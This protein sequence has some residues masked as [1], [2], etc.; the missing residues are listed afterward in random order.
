MLQK[1]SEKVS[2]VFAEEGF[3]FGHCLLVEDDVR[4]LIDSGAG[5]AL[6]D[7]HPEHIDILINSHHHIDHIRGNDQC[8]NAKVFLHPLEQQCLRE[9]EKLV[10]VTGWNELMGED[11]ATSD[12]LGITMEQMVKSWQISGDIVDGQIIDCGSTKIEVLHTPGHS[13][14]HCSFFFPEDGLVFL[15]D[16]CL[17]KVGPWYGG[18]EADIDEFIDSINRIIDLKPEKITTGHMNKVSTDYHDLI[19]YRNRIFK[20]ENKILETLKQQPKSINELADQH[21][22][23]RLHPSV[24]VLFWEKYMLKNHLERLIRMNAIEKE[25]EGRYYTKQT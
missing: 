16:I 8:P 23:Y 13:S 2:M 14:G 24:F 1:L 5:K 20:R 4:L 21:L 18:P 15:G 22:I 17:T 7:A 10:A 9:P 12:N 11:L 19:E 6:Q 25:E 3:T